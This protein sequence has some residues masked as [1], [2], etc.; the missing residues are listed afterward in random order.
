MEA[1]VQFGTLAHW[2]P[3]STG[4]GVSST[5]SGPFTLNWR[6]KGHT[7]TVDPDW[8]MPWY[9][10]FGNHEGL[11][12]HAYAL[13]GEPASHGCVRLLQRDAQ[14]LFEWGE[15]WSV[16]ASGTRVLKTGTPVF[17]IGQYD[18]EAAPPWR[19]SNWLA[20][21]AELPSFALSE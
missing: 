5:P 2:G 21:T 13:P 8:F 1:H 6:S 7:S 15:T 20:R 17:V 19:S 4:G 10:N 12:F 9:F 16:D 18:F 11:A 14:W 3:V